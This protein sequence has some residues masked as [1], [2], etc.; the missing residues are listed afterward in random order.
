M[1]KLYSTHCPQCFVLETK[2]TRAGIE[3]ELCDDLA[4]IKEK[5]F[6]ATPMLETDEGIMNFPQAIKWLNNQNEH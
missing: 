6:K 3:Y 4:I 5:G 1:I 2:L